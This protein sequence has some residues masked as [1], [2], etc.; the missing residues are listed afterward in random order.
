MLRNI[1]QSVFVGYTESSVSITASRRY[2]AASYKCCG[3]EELFCRVLAL[4]DALVKWYV[5]NP[6]P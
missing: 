6:F 4:I 2:L 1:N 5:F 3:Y